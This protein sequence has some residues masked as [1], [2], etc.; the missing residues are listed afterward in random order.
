[1]KT[2]LFAPTTLNLAETSRQIEIAKALD[3]TFKP[4]FI[5]YGGNFEHLIEDAGYT[6]RRLT[7]RFTPEQIEFLY[8][9]DR[10]EASGNP[11]TEA[12]ILERVGNEVQIMEE[13]QPV[14]VS[15]GGNLT[16]L[17]SARAAKVPLVVTMPFAM[18]RPFYE[19]GLGTWPDAFDYPITRVLPERFLNWVMTQIMLKGTY[20]VHDFN[21]IGKMFNVPPFKLTT[22]LF[23]G[24]YNLVSDIP[25]VTGV[26]KLPPK[27]RY[28]GPLFA[29]FDM[30]VP[31]DI[32]LMPRDLPIIYFAMGSSGNV[33]IVKQVL[34]GFGGKPYRVIAPIKRHL[35][36]LNVDIPDN[37]LVT[38][39]IPAHKVNPIADIS[40]I[41][42]GQGTVQTACLSGTP[43]VGIPMQPEQE[44]NLDF[45]ARLGCAI[46]IRKR[47]VTA[48]AV[49]QAVDQLLADDHAKQQALA[50]QQAYEQWDGVQ[51]AFDFFVEKF[52]ELQTS[53]N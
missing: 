43:I 51:N 21:K 37:V 50:V 44:G 47:R 35:A 27:Q 36:N 14:A 33:E 13:L 5:S 10:L 9:M 24:D 29:K 49:L 39:L 4:E 16:T 2:I 19:A 1:M 20:L 28:I 3:G 25:F 6:T 17:I 48:N 41:H 45:L 11:F 31:P 42:G 53:A 22:D 26:K 38:D 15:T 30:D 8:K 12:Q 34:A 7:P 23:E 52:G 32:E 18:T 46:H 40:V